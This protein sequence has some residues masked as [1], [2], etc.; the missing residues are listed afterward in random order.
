[1]VQV[2]GGGVAGLFPPKLGNGLGQ[3]PQHAPHPLKVLQ[4]GSFLH[5]GVDELWMEWVA[6][7]QRLAAIIALPHG[8]QGLGMAAP[9]V[10]V[11]PHHLPHPTAVDGFKQATAQHLHRLV[12]AGG[13]EGRD[14]SSRHGLQFREDSINPL[15]LLP[16]GIHRLATTAQR[17]GEHQLQRWG[18]S[19][20]P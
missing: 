11:G 9:E 16:I 5:Q 2:D 12:F 19:S 8:W 4:G 13:G 15:V 6:L 1:M 10:L 17:Q 7:A 20:L 3:Q 14:L 18:R